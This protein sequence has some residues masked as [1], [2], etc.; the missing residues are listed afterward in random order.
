MR[1]RSRKRFQQL[2]DGTAEDIDWPE[3][4]FAGLDRTRGREWQ[5]DG[6]DFKDVWFTV[7]VGSREERFHLD[8][9][10]R[11]PR[12]W[13]TGGRI[14]RDSTDGDGSGGA[15]AVRA[16]VEMTVLSTSIRM[17]Y[18]G[19]RKLPESLDA[20]TVE[21]PK[22]GEAYVERVPVDPWGNAYEFRPLGGAKFTLRSRGADGKPDTADD[23][24][25]PE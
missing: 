10:T 6:C 16:K 14:R 7:R 4:T 24:V 9:C 21:D 22:T 1:T 19:N 23:I 8:R 17:Y 15:Y 25:W 3:A 2:R 12:G 13:I 5:E 20:L 18:L 11:V